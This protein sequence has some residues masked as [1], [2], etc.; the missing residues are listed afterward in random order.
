MKMSRSSRD[1]SF[2]LLVSGSEV[3]ELTL[4][5]TWPHPTHPPTHTYTHTNPPLPHSSDRMQTQMA[6]SNLIFMINKTFLLITLSSILNTALHIRSLSGLKPLSM[7]AA[8]TGLTHFFF[9]YRSMARVSVKTFKKKTSTLVSSRGKF[10][11]VLTLSSSDYIWNK[12]LYRV[13]IVL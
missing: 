10:L 3:T 9:I 8:S 2:I 1:P 4:A 5:Y 13:S 6:Q 12:H 7:A 11:I